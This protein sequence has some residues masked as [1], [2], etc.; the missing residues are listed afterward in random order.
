MSLRLVNA[1]AGALAVVGLFALGSVALDGSAFGFHPFLAYASFAVFAPLGVLFMHWKHASLS[2]EQRLFYAQLHVASQLLTAVSAVVAFAIIFDSK[3]QR[4][5]PHFATLHGKAGLVAVLCVAGNALGV[6]VWGRA[7]FSCLSLPPTH[8][9]HSSSH[10][11]GL[12]FTF[13]A[14]L[15]S[16]KKT[17]WFWKNIFHRV[18]GT[19]AL[20][21]GWAAIVLATLYS[22]WAHAALNQEMQWFL[23]IG[24]SLFTII[25]TA[26]TIL[27]FVAPP[28]TADASKSTE[29]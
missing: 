16:G 23:V 28:S 17:Q 10:L 1:G 7:G 26:Q 5:K 20:A 4:N 12:F 8:F 15:L 3:N 13:G 27:N 29:E 21:A 14:S 6:R 24:A 11:Q 19:A 2:A 22:N 9:H 18:G 25:V